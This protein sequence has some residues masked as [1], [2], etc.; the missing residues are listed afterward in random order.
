MRGDVVGAK[1]LDSDSPSQFSY[2]K[3]DDGRMCHSA[4]SKQQVWTSLH[5]TEVMSVLKKILKPNSAKRDSVKQNPFKQKNKL[6]TT[7]CMNCSAKNPKISRPTFG[8]LHKVYLFI[9]LVSSKLIDASGHQQTDYSDI[10]RR[11]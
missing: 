5:F 1:E 9:Y 3:D 4:E 2:A 10:F 6:K 11:F 7:K 8:W